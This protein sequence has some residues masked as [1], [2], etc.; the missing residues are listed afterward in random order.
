MPSGFD[1]RYV[2]ET[3]SERRRVLEIVAVVVTG[4]GKFVFMDLLE[5]R[6][7]FIS[8][9][10]I[11][12]SMY[13]LYYRGKNSQI[14]KYWGF[15]KDNLGSVGNLVLPFGLIS[16]ASF[17]TIGYMLN[18]L[19]FTWHIIPILIIYPI[20]GTIQQFLII[21]LIAGNMKDLKGRDWSNTTI[22]LATATMFA[23]VH[24]PNLWLIF[25][26]FILALFYTYIFLKDRNVFILGIF[27]GWLGGLFFYTVVDRD[28]FIEVFGP[29]LN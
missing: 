25:G 1:E 8:T 28:P 12:W 18:T 24:Y 22:M 7:L 2:S 16:L 17:V 26:T 5:W 3:I 15:R 13:I 27:H 4:I 11:A 10:I 9:A 21:S 20:W 6:F 23:V 19:N 29:L 14:L